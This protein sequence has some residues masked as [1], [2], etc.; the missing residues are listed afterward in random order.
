M[1][2]VTGDMALVTQNLSVE[3]SNM[4]MDGIARIMDQFEAQSEELDLHGKYMDGAIGNSTAGTT[5]A[6]EVNALLKSVR[7]LRAA[8]HCCDQGIPTLLTRPA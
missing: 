3:M 6:N 5:P 7:I 2:K 4:N 8:I 1:N